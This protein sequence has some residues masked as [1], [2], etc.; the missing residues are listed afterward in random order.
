MCYFSGCVLL[1]KVILCSD[2][3]KVENGTKK[4]INKGENKTFRMQNNLQKYQKV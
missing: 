4:D 1:R 2:L 3:Q